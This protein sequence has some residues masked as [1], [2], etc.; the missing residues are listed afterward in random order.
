MEERTVDK[1]A[2]DQS[3]SFLGKLVSFI[4]IPWDKMMMYD[5]G[6]P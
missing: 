6:R 5:D 4:P 2:N 1:A 3:W